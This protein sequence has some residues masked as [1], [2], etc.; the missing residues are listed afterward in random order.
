MYWQ[1]LKYFINLVTLAMPI[2]R[3]MGCR[4]RRH[5]WALEGDVPGLEPEF[6]LLEGVLLSLFVLFSLIII[7]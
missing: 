1:H 2:F 7:Y 3:V 4:G 5:T 6:C